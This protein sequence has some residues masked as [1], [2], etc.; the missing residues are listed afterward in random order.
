MEGGN[1]NDVLIKINAMLEEA[2]PLLTD[3]CCI[4]RVPHEIRKFKKDAY[5]P[6]VVSIGPFHH[7]NPKLLRMEDQKRLYCRQFIERS[8]TKNLKSFVSCVQ[9][10]EP[11]VRRCYSDDI[12]LSI[13][14]HI[15]VILV[16]C[17]FILELLCRYHHRD[18]ILLPPRLG[19]FMHYDLLLLENQ[20]PFFVLEKLHNLAFPSTLNSRGQNNYPSLLWLTFHYII[21]NYIISS[22]KVGLSLSNVSTI[23]HFTDLSRKLLLISSH[24]FQ[25]SV[26]GCSRTAEVTHLYSASKLKEAGVNFEVNKNSQCLLDLQLSGHTLRI[27]FIRVDDNTEIVLRNLLA[28]EQCH[29]VNESYLTDYITVFDYLINTDKDVDLLIKKGIID[30]WL[31]DSNA[32]AEMFNGLG[33]NIMQTDFNVKYSSI[34][35]DLNDFCAHPWNRKVATLRRDYCNTPWKTVASIA[36]I[37]LLIL[38]IIQTV[39]SILQVV[40]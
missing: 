3:E 15:R 23:A 8:E 32:V 34:F 1:P 20:V 27:P 13:E 6:K 12:K 16:D 19:N 2:Q 5:T 7:G 24:L 18:A 26:S 29:C 28:F 36:G 14:K 39:F 30:N 11:E 17:C 38:T 21:P 25:P 40:H 4:Y 10:L 9:E 37:F 31:S 22:D 35:Q 33:V